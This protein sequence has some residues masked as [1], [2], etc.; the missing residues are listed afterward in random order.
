MEHSV[1]PNWERRQRQIPWR[2][3]I[4]GLQELYEREIIRM[5]INLYRQ[6]NLYQLTTPSLSDHEMPQNEIYEL[7]ARRHSEYLSGSNSMY[8]RIPNS[9]VRAINTLRTGSGRISFDHVYNHHVNVARADQGEVVMLLIPGYNTQIV[10][11]SLPVPTLKWNNQDLSGPIN[12]SVMV[13]TEGQEL[14]F[15]RWMVEM[16]DVMTEE[17][18]DADICFI[19]EGR[20]RLAGNVEDGFAASPMA[21]LLPVRFTV[22]AWLDDQEAHEARSRMRETFAQAQRASLETAQNRER[23]AIAAYR[24]AAQAVEIAETSEDEYLDRMISGLKVPVETDPQV[25]GLWVDRYSKVWS[26][27]GP[28][29][30]QDNRDYGFFLICLQEQKAWPISHDWSGGAHCNIRGR[31]GGDFC[32]GGE[33]TSDFQKL[34]AQ[35]RYTDAVTYFIYRLSRPGGRGY[36]IHVPEYQPKILPDALK[37]VENKLA[38]QRGSDI[39][40]SRK[41]VEK[42]KEFFQ[43]KYKEAIEVQAGLPY[44]S[45]LESISLEEFDR[46]TGGR[47]E[48]YDTTNAQ[49]EAYADGLMSGVMNVIHYPTDEDSDEW[50]VWTRPQGTYQFGSRP[51]AGGARVRDAHGRFARTTQESQ[52]DEAAIERLR[53][54]DHAEGGVLMPS[55]TRRHAGST[56]TGV[57]EIAGRYAFTGGINSPRTWGGITVESANRPD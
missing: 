57:A 43:G 42:V 33:G 23:E 13:S 35:C 45:E 22:M 34:V 44:E 47:Y 10:R 11:W 38:P 55:P 16:C 9:L 40:H 17:P 3:E 54:I 8:N 50:T 2:P 28:I 4:S 48:E 37:R 1:F 12:E 24:A 20:N 6:Q 21:W 18:G 46:R 14:M 56:A 49:E 52:A 29:K 27:V 36:N 39:F 15:P 41:E 31:E 32:M 25:W 5:T 7:I 30:T 53:Q 51:T 26:V 19:F